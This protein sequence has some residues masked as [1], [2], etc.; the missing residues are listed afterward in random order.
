MAESETDAVKLKAA[1]SLLDMGIKAAAIAQLE[2]RIVEL[3]AA[4]KARGLL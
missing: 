1:T 3:E 2:Q 4:I